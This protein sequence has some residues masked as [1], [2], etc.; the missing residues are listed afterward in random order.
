MLDL[1]DVLAGAGT[2]IDTAAGQTPN[3]K[4]KKKNQFY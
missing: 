4:K 1:L 2:R 3:K